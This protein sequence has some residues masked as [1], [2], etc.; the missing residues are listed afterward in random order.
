MKRIRVAVVFGGRSVEHPV[1]CASGSGVVSALDPE[2]FDVVPVGITSSGGW[3][4]L[5]D[6]AEKLAIGV[7]DDL[8]AITEDSGR[9][10]ALSADPTARQLTVGDP[11]EGAAALADVDVVFPAL[12]GPYGEDGTLQGLLEMAGIPYVG[13]GVLSSS[14]CMDKEFTKRLLVAE[15]IPTG[16]YAVLRGEETVGEDDRRRLGLPVFVKPARAGSSVGITKVD[17]WRQ[18]PDALRAA[19]SVDPK[20]IVEAAFTGAR[21]LECGVL[22][23]EDGGVDATPPLEVL[24]SGEDGWFDFQ[25]KYLGSP[26]PF[27]LSPDLPDGVAQRVRN[28]AA[29]VFTTLDCS[30]LAR[31]D[32]FLAADGEV[33]VNEINTMPGLT[34]MSGVPQAWAAAGLPYSELVARLVRMAVKRGTGLR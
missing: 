31:V 28:L 17:S 23:R 3:V 33:Y 34:P 18:L 14:V 8:P 5:G 1:S 20:V 12:H 10:V 13:S 2:Q 4:Q 22:E 21:E 29:R 15:G 19:R 11:A 24:E 9:Q 7:G 6:E 30:D 27:N 32:F 16:P 25:A 26:E